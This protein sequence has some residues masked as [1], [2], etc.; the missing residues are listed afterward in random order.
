[1]KTETV[2]K[3]AAEKAKAKPQRDGK[4]RFVKGNKGGP[5]YPKPIAVFGEGGPRI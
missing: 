5:K 4:G 2:N 1:M 3:P